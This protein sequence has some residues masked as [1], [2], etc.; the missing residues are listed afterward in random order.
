MKNLILLFTVIFG[1]QYGNN[2]EKMIVAESAQEET[3]FLSLQ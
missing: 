3:E 2:Q 1:L